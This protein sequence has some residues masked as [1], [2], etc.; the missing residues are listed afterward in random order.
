M[1]NEL[2][3]W[4]AL[5]ADAATK[6]Q[7]A[8]L[9]HLGTL[10]WQKG[11]AEANAGN[12]SLRLPHTLQQSTWD[13]LKH[14]LSQSQNKTSDNPKDYHWFLVSASGSRYRQYI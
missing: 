4:S 12:V 13:C 2:E 1:S 11:W 7:L 14:L 6:Q 5:Q 8:D 9:L 3:L 10:L